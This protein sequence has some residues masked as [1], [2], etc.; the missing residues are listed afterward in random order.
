[1][2]TD[3]HNLV[4]N[5]NFEAGTTAGWSQTGG[6]LAVSTA[7]A[8]SGTNSLVDAARTQ[9]YQGQSWNLP[10]GT[11]K[12]NVVFYVL[13]SGSLPHSLILQ[14]TYTCGT[15]APQYPAPAGTLSNVAGGNWNQLSGTVTFPPADAPAGC[16]L[17]SA[18]LYLQ[19]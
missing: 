14:P 2:V 11:A 9:I 10:I 12:Y 3:G 8:H 18:S 6:T 13:H 19:Q 16:Q 17:T 1:T 15:G 5:P 4:G 7:W